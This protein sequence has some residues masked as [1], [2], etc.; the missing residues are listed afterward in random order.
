MGDVTHRSISPS[1]RRLGSAFFTATVLHNLSN[2]SRRIN[3]NARRG[4]I[5][6]TF[7]ARINV[8]SAAAINSLTYFMAATGAVATTA[9]VVAF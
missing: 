8:R 5:E 3:Q 2:L 9:M 1:G 4:E 6:F 7:A